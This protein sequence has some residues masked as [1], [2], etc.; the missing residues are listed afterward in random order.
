MF[1]AKNP[2]T[3][4]FLLPFKPESAEL[5]PDVWILRDVLGADPLLPQRAQLDQNYPNPFNAGTTMTLRLPTRAHAVVRLYDILGRRVTT[6]LEGIQEPGSHAMYW[7]GMTDT[8]QPAASG[9]YF[10]RLETNEV[11]LTRQLLTSPITCPMTHPGTALI[12]GASAG[13]GKAFARRLAH[14]HYNLILHG[15]REPLLTALCE[16]L[17]T[18][19]ASRPMS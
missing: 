11:T 7:D 13:I 12:T 2:E 10:V 9:V 8:A 4:E 14:E 1:N 5:D 15:R 17:R 19:M 3:F 16:E 18:L 6:L